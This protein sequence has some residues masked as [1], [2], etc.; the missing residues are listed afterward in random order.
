MKRIT[1]IITPTDLIVSALSSGASCGC[2]GSLAQLRG[3]EQNFFSGTFQNMRMWLT[4]G[5]GCNY[6]RTHFLGA[7]RDL[8]YRPSAR[9]ELRSNEEGVDNCERSP[10]VTQQKKWSE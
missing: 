9:L 10:P 7:L 5:R 6:K 2:L 4:E 1:F 3:R 8:E